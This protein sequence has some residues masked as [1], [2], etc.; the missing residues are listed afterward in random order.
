MVVCTSN[1]RQIGTAFLAYSMDNRNQWPVLTDPVNVWNVWTFEGVRLEAML[2]PYTGVPADYN[3][4]P[5]VGGGIW[6]CPASGLRAGRTIL[7][8]TQI[9]RGYEVWSRPL[10]I[11]W[12]TATQGC[13][14]TGCSRMRVQA[15]RCELRRKLAAEL[16]KKALRRAGSM[17]L[18]VPCQLRTRSSSDHPRGTGNWEAW[19]GR[20]RLPM[21][22]RLF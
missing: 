16:H 21:G 6:I 22:T 7:W 1:L 4:V 9:E 2:A 19:A 20:W 3:W 12:R 17:V 18:D 15:N 8:G 11:R 14:I 13:S 5:K 10:T